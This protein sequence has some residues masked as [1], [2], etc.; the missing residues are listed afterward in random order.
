MRI[1]RNGLLIVLTGIALLLGCERPF[2]DEQ[3]PSIT[4]LEPDLSQVLLDNTV[5]LR[6]AATS[7]RQ[8]TRVDL[9]DAAM[10]YDASSQTWQAPL[11]LAPGLNL[12]ALTAT[13]ENGTTTT[14]TLP[15]IFMSAQFQATPLELPRPLGGHTA[16]LLANGTVLVAG[17]AGAVGGDALPKVYTLAPRALAFQAVELDL[18]TGRTGHTAT[19]LPDGRVLIVGGSRTDSPTDVSDLIASAEVFDPADLTF[20]EIPFE[21]DPI[22]RTDHTALLHLTN[23]GQTLDV[24]G[25]RG[26]I[27]SDAD[28]LLSIRRDLR[29]FVFRN[30]SL[31]ALHPG[32][33]PYLEPVAGHTE[34]PLATLGYGERGRYLVSNGYFADNIADSLNFLL[35]YNDPLGL[36]PAPAD[37]LNL[38]RTDHAAAL[39]RTGFVAFFGGRRNA[40]G[41]AID[42][43]EL[44]IESVDRTLRLPVTSTP[45]G[46][47]F[48]LTATNVAFGRILLLGGFSPD[49]TGTTASAFFEYDL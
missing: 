45:L 19:L 49:G 5:T 33:G 15:A 8:V 13:D 7:F 44:Y 2:I 20:K 17:G 31:I 39:L 12:I 41:D 48:D 24:L 38:A 25:G 47:R 28:P 23:L 22:R 16:T 9:G 34:T 36:L 10:S 4:V 11:L 14:D 30:D 29:S 46:K 40:P 1:S 6:V 42:T 26:N 43:V 35:D 27:R 3:T 18:I 37:P 21:G 32:M